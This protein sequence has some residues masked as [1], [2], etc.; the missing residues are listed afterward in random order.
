MRI[1]LAFLE[2]KLPYPML[3]V[4]VTGLPLFAGVSKFIQGELSPGQRDQ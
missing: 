3:R 1:Q 2:T 4:L